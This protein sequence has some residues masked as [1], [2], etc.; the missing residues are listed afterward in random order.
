MLFVLRSFEG[1]YEDSILCYWDFT[2]RC[3]IAPG[4][5]FTGVGRW[6]AAITSLLL[7]CGLCRLMNCVFLLGSLRYL[8][9]VPSLCDFS[10]TRP[11]HWCNYTSFHPWF[12]FLPCKIFTRVSHN[13]SVAGTGT[14]ASHHTHKLYCPP[15]T[16]KIH[17][18][19]VLGSF[20]AAGWD[21]G[22]IVLWEFLVHPVI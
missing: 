8:G 6:T 17:S 22:G 21:L 4:C 19:A 3:N 18:S 9:S 12:P 7:S 5:K 15:R 10:F 13:H 14:H 2:E 16:A 20:K 11:R 1:R